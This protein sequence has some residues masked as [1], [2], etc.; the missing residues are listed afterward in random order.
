M[1]RFK[2]AESVDYG[3][4][5]KEGPQKKDRVE[6]EDHTIARFNSFL[7]PLSNK[8]LCNLKQMLEVCWC[9][10]LFYVVLCF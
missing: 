6:T 4:R 2:E 10:R 8:L 3:M 5:Y 1:E 9:D 7:M